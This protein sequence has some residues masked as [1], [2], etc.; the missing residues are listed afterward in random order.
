MRVTSDILIS[1]LLK[2]VDPKVTIEDTMGAMAELVKYFL[3]TKNSP[4]PHQNNYL[5]SFPL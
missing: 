2:R 1:E 3:N 5:N 4:L